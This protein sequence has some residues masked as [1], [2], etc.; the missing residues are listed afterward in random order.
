M[1]SDQCKMFI[2][3]LKTYNSY[4]KRVSFVLTT[5]STLQLNVVPYASFLILI[6]Y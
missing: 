2:L 5:F 1:L 3:V 4:T 6:L